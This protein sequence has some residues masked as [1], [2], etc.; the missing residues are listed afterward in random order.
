MTLNWVWLI[1]AVFV[2]GALTFDLK[3]FMRKAYNQEVKSW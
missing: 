3:V 1:F 2:L